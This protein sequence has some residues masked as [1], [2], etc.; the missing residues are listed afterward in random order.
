ML[1]PLRNKR[2]TDAYRSGQEF[3]NYEALC[4]GEDILV[5]SF[6]FTCICYFL[7]TCIYYF[8]FTYIYYLLFICYV[9]KS[10]SR[11]VFPKTLKIQFVKQVFELNTAK[12]HS[13]TGVLEFKS[14]RI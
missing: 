7:F 2:V 6:L 12:Y 1:P 4:R 3:M 14:L 13:M 9:Y 8:L 11:P 10:A 5:S